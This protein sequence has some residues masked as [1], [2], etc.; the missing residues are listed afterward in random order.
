MAMRIRTAC[1]IEKYVRYVCAIVLVPLFLVERTFFVIASFFGR[2]AEFFAD[3]VDWIGESLDDF[4]NLLFRKSNIASEVR[5][6]ILYE[7]LTAINACYNE[8][9]LVKLYPTLSKDD[10][11][12]TASEPLA[13]RK[14]NRK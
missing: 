13:S 1:I 10:F 5:N 14:Y 11:K 4:G 3:V 7:N 8:D 2:I 12:T 9:E 6:E